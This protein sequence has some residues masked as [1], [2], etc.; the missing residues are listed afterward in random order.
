MNPLSLLVAALPVG[1]R[2]LVRGPLGR[3]PRKAI[4]TAILAMTGML[5]GVFSPQ[6]AES[7]DGFT[8]GAASW[9]S[10]DGWIL[11]EQADGQVVYRGEGSGDTFSRHRTLTLGTSWRIEVDVRF[12][13]YFS[14]NNTRAVA[15]FAL[16]PAVDAGVQLEANLSHRTNNS[17][18]LDGQWFNVDTRTWPNVLLAEWSPS[19]SPVYRMQ[20]TRSAGSS[21]LVL[22]VTGG[23]G[24]SYRG[25]T[26][27]IPADVLNRQKVPGLRVNSG[28]VEYDNFRL[29][30]PFS[31]PP[32]P[33]VIS[34]PTNLTVFSGQPA[35]FRV[36][37]TDSRPLTY[38][39]R[40]GTV[41]LAGATNE[42]FTIAKATPSF[43]G[44]YS[45]EISNGETSTVTTPAL[46]TVV[47]G[48]FRPSAV[49][50]TN[51]PN[52]A[53]F[54][55]EVLAPTGAEFLLQRSADLAN[56]TEV[57][58]AVGTGVAS[59]FTFPAATKEAGANFRLL[60]H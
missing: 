1:F 4:P 45:V 6:A 24:F 17:V 27:V 5:F 3:L 55:V 34:A 20:L 46:L 48:Y 21:R 31:L 9:L 58:R 7:V 37:A 30:Q 53:G 41:R 60:F 19:R 43:F 14:D 54:T 12:R 16:F 26:A 18:Q 22:R 33:V 40:R 50:R 52:L 38:Q 29:I 56:W 23:D 59:E 44:G 51:D 42:T 13:R 39:W 49:S 10:N 47:G 28:Q 8:A 25:E 35:S 57:A 11:V 36:A 2:R 32:A 15:G